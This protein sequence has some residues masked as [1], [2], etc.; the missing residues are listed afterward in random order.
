M[1]Y[2]KRSWIR[3]TVPLT[4]DEHD[5]FQEKCK[6]ECMSQSQRA[7]SLIRGDVGMVRK[8]NGG[9]CARAS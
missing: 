7:R 3:V 1:P 9:S 5:R 6:D 2:S 8:G 4:P